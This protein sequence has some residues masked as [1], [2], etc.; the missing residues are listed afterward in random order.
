MRKKALAILLSVVMAMSL[1]TACGKAD[2]KGEVTKEAA[3]AGETITIN[4]FDANPYAPEE[5][6]DMVAKFEAEH[7]GVL[8]EVQHAANDSKTLLQ[9][10]VNSGDIPDVFAVQSGSVADMYYEYAYDWSNDAE[11]LKLFNEDALDRGR[12]ADGAVK[13][14]PWFYENMGM[15][16]NKD[17]FEKAGITE[18]PVNVQELEEVC[19]KLDAAGITPFAL[20][21]K[22]VWILAQMTSHFILDKSLDGMG[23]N[24]A[25]LNGDLTFAELPNFQNVFKLLDLAVEYGP[26]KPLEIDWEVSENMFANGEAAMIQMGDWCQPT[27][28]SFNP[29]AR[30][31]FLPMPVGEAAEDTTVLSASNWVLMINKDSENLEIAKEYLV[32]ILTSEEGLNWICDDMRLVPCAKTDKEVNAML[33][34]DA[35]TYIEA[36]KTNGWLHTIAPAAYAEVCGSYIQAYMTG[37]MTKE[38]VTQGFQELWDAE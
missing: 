25:L 37:D 5:F 16:Y 28:D 36:G 23:T 34:N 1:M 22:E 35:K 30:T 7:P 14:L 11:I 10:R 13:A 12:D 9:S 2:T 19:K 24:E 6:A 18:L 3:G 32:Y 31:A 8:V 20:G 15:L 26:G 29:D 38:E 27:L 4:T 17:C 21:A 33:A